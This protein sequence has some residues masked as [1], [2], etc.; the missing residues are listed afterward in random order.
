MISAVFGWLW[1]Q[2]RDS[3]IEE[4]EQCNTDKMASVADAERL[5]RE[6]S[7]N[8]HARRESELL[9]II[10]AEREARTIADTGRV[11]ANE[12]ADAAVARVNELM[13]EIENENDAPVARLCVNTVL[14]GDVRGVYDDGHSG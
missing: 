9:A 10:Q 5:A 4:R 8:A 13:R 2:A 12:I 6:A 11:E 7:D 14:P 1:L 3:I